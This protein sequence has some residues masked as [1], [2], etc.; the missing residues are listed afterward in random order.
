MKNIIAI[1]KLD[2]VDNPDGGN[3]VGIKLLRGS[4]GVLVKLDGFSDLR[5]NDGEVVLIENR[6][7]NPHV[8]V[9][10]DINSEDPTHVINLAGANKSRRKNE[11][12]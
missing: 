9:W 11:S 3:S 7:G 8:I 12:H 5:S 4:Y 1:D 10:G 6:E 2:D